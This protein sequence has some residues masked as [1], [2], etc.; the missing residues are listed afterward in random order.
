M[1]KFD[2]VLFMNGQIGQFNGSLVEK[3]IKNQVPCLFKCKQY[4]KISLTKES[5]EKNDK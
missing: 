2:I 3:Q 5:I 1:T 4:L